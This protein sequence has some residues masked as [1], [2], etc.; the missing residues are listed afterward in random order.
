[1][2]T[3]LLEREKVVQEGGYLSYRDVLHIKKIKLFST[4]LFQIS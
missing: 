1:M 2:R 3:M 4:Y